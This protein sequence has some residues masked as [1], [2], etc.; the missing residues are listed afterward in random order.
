MSY[1]AWDLLKMSN[2]QANNIDVELVDYWDS[3]V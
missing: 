2:I 3:L 1:V